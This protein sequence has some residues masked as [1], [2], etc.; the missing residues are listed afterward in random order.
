MLVF[1]GSSAEFAV[2]P[3][4]EWLFY[5]GKLLA[6]PVGRFVSTLHYVRRL[7]FASTDAE[8]ARSA[9]D[10]RGIHTALEE[11]RGRA[12]PALAYRDV[13]F[14]NLEY[15]V[16]AFPFVFGRDLSV[17]EKDEIV[18]DFSVAG[19]LMAV[20]DLPITFSDYLDIRAERYQAFVYTEWT[21]RL[22]R[23][24]SR[25]IGSFHYRF[26]L[27]PVYAGLIAP[28]IRTILRLRPHPNAWL[29]KALSYPACRIGLSDI[30]FSLFLPRR[31][32]E[33]IKGWG[34]SPA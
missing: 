20:Q 33:A 18:R 5:T 24:Y 29:F 26:F 14:M 12:I 7:I 27:L 4:S 30:F 13:L 3:F 10:I 23:A 1:A 15:S 11:R 25:A 21:D 22:L 16:R 9:S 31:S 8:H 17:A 34:S 19:E 6:D 32:Y 2:N 28:E